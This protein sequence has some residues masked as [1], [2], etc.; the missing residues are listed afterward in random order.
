[1][2]KTRNFKT[3]ASGCDAGNSFRD[4]SFGE[5]AEKTGSA[6]NEMRMAS[7]QIA[8]FDAQIFIDQ[9]LGQQIRRRID[10]HDPGFS[11]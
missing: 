4:W 1:M 7:H 3:Y 11:K 9:S 8:S 5:R 2:N 6:R 10:Q